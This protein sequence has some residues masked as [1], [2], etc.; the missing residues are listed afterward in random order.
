MDYEK[1][2]EQWL[3]SDELSQDE[4]ARL[5]ALNEEEKKEMF[6]CPLQFGTA[7]MRGVLDLGTNRMNVFTVRR[8]TKGL[9]EYI[10]TLGEEAM[11]R[12]VVISY[13]TRRFSSEFSIEVAKVL[14]K[15]N[16]NT[17]LF[18]TV[19]PV[20]MCSFAIRRLNA[21]AGVMIT[22][23]HNP[24]STTDTKFTA[25]TERRCRPNRR[26]KWSNL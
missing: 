20:P 8:A 1:N 4:K 5:R 9:A 15:N 17:Y 21:I 13:D 19:H 18:D 12:G 2:F 14:A 22:A 25:R 16:I 7:G 23:S 10:K 24:K 26:I 6:F 3:Q 11:Q